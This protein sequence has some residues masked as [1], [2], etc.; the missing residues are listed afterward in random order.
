MQSIANRV[1]KSKL[2]AMVIQELPKEL[3][4]TPTQ[5]LV[6]HH[7]GTPEEYRMVDGALQISP[8]QGLPYLALLDIRFTC[9]AEIHCNLLVDSGSVEP[10]GLQGDSIPIVHIHQESYSQ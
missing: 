3:K 5:T 7:A 1:F 9:N 2:T 6:I 10:G 8:L 4:L